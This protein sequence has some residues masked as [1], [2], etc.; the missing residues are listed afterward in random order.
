M[1]RRGRGADGQSLEKL[2]RLRSELYRARELLEMIVQRETLRKETI[3][4]EQTVFEKRVEVRRMKHKLG[5]VDVD[6]SPEKARKRF[7]PDRCV[8]LW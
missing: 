8:P 2:N 5:V 1:R 7:R 3:A 4:I 6:S